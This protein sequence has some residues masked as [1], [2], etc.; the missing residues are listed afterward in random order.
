MPKKPTETGGWQVNKD[1]QRVW[2]TG[3]QGRDLDQD[4]LDKEKFQDTSLL[5]RAAAENEAKKGKASV[6]P[7]GPPVRGP[8]EAAGAF[9][10]RQ[11]DYE[12]AAAQKKALD[13]G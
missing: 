11:A 1:G 7:S 10:K 9:K 2:V 3:Q 12:K 4:V 8:F 6:A 13:R 5:G